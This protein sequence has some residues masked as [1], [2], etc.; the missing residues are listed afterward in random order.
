MT[1]VH[2]VSCA[3]LTEVCALCVLQVTA[4]GG[5]I[6]LASVVFGVAVKMLSE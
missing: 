2:C 4:S 6:A 1:A 5:L 3:L